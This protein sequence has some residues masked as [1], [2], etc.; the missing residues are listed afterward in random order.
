MN[1]SADERIPM[2]INGKTL[3][4]KELG[5]LKAE[6]PD[7]IEA[8]AEARSHGD[9]R[10]NAEY[11]AARERQGMTEARI[12]DIEYKLSM[13]QVID[14]S[15]MSNNGRVI[16]GVT[17]ELCNKKDQKRVSYKIV[18]EDESDVDQGMIAYK[19][20]IARELIGKQIGDEV[21]IGEEL[22]TIESVH[23]KA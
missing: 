15:T 14:V 20:P 3:L 12:K 4:E 22:Y 2:T 7:I 13:A 18:G 11:H 19:A 16:F 21:L 6:R 17:I 1:A 5:V 10:E 23:Y 8:I 9:L